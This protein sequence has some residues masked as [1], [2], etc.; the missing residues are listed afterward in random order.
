VVAGR[1]AA[2]PRWIPLTKRS[3]GGIQ[4]N[5]CLVSSVEAVLSVPGVS[6]PRRRHE[7]SQTTSTGCLQDVDFCVFGLLILHTEHREFFHAQ[8]IEQSCKSASIKW[9]QWGSPRSQV[10]P[11]SRPNPPFAYERIGQSSQPVYRQQCKQLAP[12]F[13]T[14]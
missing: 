7:G 9:C 6:Q 4:T 12:P 8:A 3:V 14:R 5:V 1:R 11:E 10:D 2:G 13:F